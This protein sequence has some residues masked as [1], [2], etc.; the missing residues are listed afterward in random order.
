MNK[1]SVILSELYFIG[2]TSIFITQVSSTFY[3]YN[4]N[5]HTLIYMFHFWDF[6]Y[7]NYNN[8]HLKP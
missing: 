2:Q 7:I 3:P 6:G 1:C 8:I 5:N 4:K